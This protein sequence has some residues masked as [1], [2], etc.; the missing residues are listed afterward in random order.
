VNVIDFVR[1]HIASI[2]LLFACCLARRKYGPPYYKFQLGRYTFRM[3]GELVDVLRDK[4]A[5]YG[6]DQE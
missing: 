2:G 3:P 4:L 1:Y 6:A 5:T